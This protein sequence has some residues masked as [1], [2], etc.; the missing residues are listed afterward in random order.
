M[1]MFAKNNNRVI[2]VEH[3]GFSRQKIKDIPNITKR[4]VKAL[5]QKHSTKSNSEKNPHIITPLLLPP[6][7]RA[8]NLLNDKIFLKILAKRISKLCH[9]QPIIWTYLATSTVLNLI[10]KLSP[11]L[12]V[13]DCVYDAPEHPEAPSD[14]ERTEK[15]LLKLADIVFTDANYLYQLKK[16]HNPNVYR[17][18]PGVDF[19]HFNIHPTLKQK[20]LP[21]IKDTKKP[22][23]CSFGSIDNMRIDL[24]LIDLISNRRPDW[25]IIMIGPIVNIKI[26]EKLLCR[27][28]IIWL[29][30]KNY[31]E[32]PLYLRE[33][34]ALILPYKLN[35][36]TQSIFPAKIFECLATGKVI[37]STP[38]PELSIFKDLITIATNHSD[39]IKGVENALFNDTDA[40]KKTRT[41]FASDNSWDK[42]YKIIYE[43]IESVLDKKV[44]I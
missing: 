20:S 10:K 18:L 13:Y 42:R 22:R 34:D 5:K 23:I 15:K 43:K 3:L 16:E 31:E 30:S 37:I 21:D 27:K 33:C 25:S 38:L 2:F 4:I 6:I 40:A 1:E 9:K 11:Q 44:G 32:L 12:I 28:N 39:F 8:C 36:F 35:Q 26:P 14:I 19:E 17:V 29:G 41:T 24:D 7:N